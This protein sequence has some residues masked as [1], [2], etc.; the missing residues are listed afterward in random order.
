MHV[1]LSHKPFEILRPAARWRGSQILV[2]AS[3]RYSAR[4][5]AGLSRRWA[6]WA[7]D[8]PHCLKPLFSSSLEL[9]KCLCA[10]AW[11][12]KDCQ[13]FLML[14]PAGSIYFFFF[15]LSWLWLA[16]FRP[17]SGKGSDGILL[18]HLYPKAFAFLL[19]SFGRVVASCLFRTTC[20]VRVENRASAL[21]MIT[22][23]INLIIST[24][25]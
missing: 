6:V 23:V 25:S 17:V 12:S 8:V 2:L 13:R 22:Y 11:T 10:L 14:G 3:V 15:L 16:S 21:M 20:C 9:Q 24:F 18:T 1:L 4:N 19:G 7:L 5:K